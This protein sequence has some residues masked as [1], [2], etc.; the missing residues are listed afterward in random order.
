[1]FQLTQPGEVPVELA[2]V[3][4]TIKVVQEQD[5][6]RSDPGLISLHPHQAGTKL[7]Q[8][9]GAHHFALY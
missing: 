4:P 2:G 5:R 7:S 1:M 9:S 3:W 6:G 8:D